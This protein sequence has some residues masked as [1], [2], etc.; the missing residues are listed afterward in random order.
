M[1][2]AKVRL[3]L[4]ELSKFLHKTLNWVESAEAAV[5]ELFKPWAGSDQQSGESVREFAMRKAQEERRIVA[6]LKRLGCTTM[7]DIMA[8]MT[9]LKMWTG[10]TVAPS[11]RV[12]AR[13]LLT[14][15]KLCRPRNFLPNFS[16]RSRTTQSQTH[17]Y[18]PPCNS[19]QTSS[20]HSRTIEY[21]VHSACRFQP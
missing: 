16:D 10:V 7:E 1:V 11:T 20:A 19:I 17:A 21:K 15:K 18:C 6:E 5:V 3:V 8:L 13:T 14:Q 12:A 9:G 2:L 4:V